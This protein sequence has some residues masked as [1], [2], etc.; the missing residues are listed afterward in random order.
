[1]DQNRHSLY[2]VHVQ[3]NL[4]GRIDLAMRI[5]ITSNPI[6]YLKPKILIFVVGTKL[7]V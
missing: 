7:L 1:M 3:K 4:K 6:V 2:L 5:H